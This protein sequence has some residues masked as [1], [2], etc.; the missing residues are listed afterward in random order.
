M[1]LSGV[2]MAEPITWQNIPSGGSSSF[3]QPSSYG[4]SNPYKYESRSRTK[5]KYDLTKPEDKM[6]YDL[7]PAAKIK[8][9]INPMVGIDQGLG[10][11]GG[12]SE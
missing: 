9:G 6:R 3:G 1:F 11:Y 4:G 10:Q 12:G 5:Y 7:D 8:D 2:A